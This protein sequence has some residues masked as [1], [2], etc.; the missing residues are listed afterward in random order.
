MRCSISRLN[1]NK[2]IIW[3][4][5][6]IIWI[7]LNHLCALRWRRPTR[8]FKEFMNPSRSLLCICWKIN[9]LETL[10]QIVVKRGL[11]ENEIHF[12]WIPKWS[13][14]VEDYSN[15]SQILWAFLWF[16]SDLSHPSERIQIIF[17]IITEGGDSVVASWAQ[18]QIKF[19]P[20][21]FCNHKAQLIA[22]K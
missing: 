8:G 3:R 9:K 2:L 10:K 7:F 15:I 21:P 16:I 17:A 1:E 4:L 20:E 6:Y 22:L 11:N 12:L 5:F 13:N 19:K 18:N 14:S